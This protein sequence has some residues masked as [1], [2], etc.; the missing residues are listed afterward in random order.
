MPRQA[1]SSSRVN[2]T[3]L[4]GTVK[5]SFRTKRRLVAFQTTFQKIGQTRVE[6]ILMMEGINISE[7]TV[8]GACRRY[9]YVYVYLDAIIG[10]RISEEVHTRPQ[11]MNVATCKPRGCPLADAKK[12]DLC[13]RLAL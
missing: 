4:Q 7:Q 2:P 5:H 10:G 9:M 1:I 13:S 8:T 11:E 12:P 6:S 3:L